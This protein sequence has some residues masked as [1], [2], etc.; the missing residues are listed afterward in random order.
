[1]HSMSM[2]SDRHDAAWPAAHNAAASAPHSEQKMGCR[3]ESNAI[4]HAPKLEKLPNSFT[5]T[6]LTSAS[7]K[8]NARRQGP[9][10]TLQAST[11]QARTARRM[12]RKRANWELKPMMWKWVLKWDAA[13]QK[14]KHG[15]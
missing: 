9:A 11:L 5:D 10:P 3:E 13:P 8:E 6:T 1:M 7:V 12:H 14:L 15:H 4:P 2:H